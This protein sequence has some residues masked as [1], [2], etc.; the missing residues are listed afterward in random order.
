MEIKCISTGSKGNCYLLKNKLGETIILDCGIKFDKI[1]IDKDFPY[2]E[3]I[4]CCLC[5][6]SHID[7]K[8]SLKDIEKLGVKIISYDNLSIKPYDIKN[9]IIFPFKVKHNAECYGFIIK[10]KIS[11]KVIAYCTDMNELP[12]LKNIDYWLIECNYT[13]ELIEQNI[14]KAKNNDDKNYFIFEN[15]KKN[16]MSLTKLYNY[17]SNKEIKKPKML[18]LCHTS[19]NNCDRKLAEKTMKLQCEQTYIVKDGENYLL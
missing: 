4:V 3:K 14:R 5:T 7:H 8:K 6:H 17:F 9:Y 16:H 15:A 2:V 11:K 18:L 12:L 13:E 1:V 19:D 10:D